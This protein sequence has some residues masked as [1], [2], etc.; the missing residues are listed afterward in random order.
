MYLYITSGQHLQAFQIHCLPGE[1][2]RKHNE[3]KE[4]H[5]ESRLAHPVEMSCKI[6][7]KSGAGKRNPI[8][9]LHISITFVTVF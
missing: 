4:N 5:D 8:N 3:D 6:S 2:S 9:D 7:Q 1:S